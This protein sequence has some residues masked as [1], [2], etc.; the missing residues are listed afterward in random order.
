MNRLRICCL[1]VCGAPQFEFETSA[2]E[3]V[4]FVTSQHTAGA[5]VSLYVVLAFTAHYYLS[6][7]GNLW[8]YLSIKSGL[9]CGIILYSAFTNG[10]LCIHSRLK[11]KNRREARKCLVSWQDLKSCLY[12]LFFWNRLSAWQ[13]KY[14]Y[15]YSESMGNVLTGERA[16][17]SSTVYELTPD[18]CPVS[19]GIFKLYENLDMD[20]TNRGAA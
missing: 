18:S 3:K 2:V 8:G 1:H 17:C 9:P 15:I 4:L 20:S 12:S 7:H 19:T 16:H 5:V 10:K 11:K 13:H 14:I 6:T